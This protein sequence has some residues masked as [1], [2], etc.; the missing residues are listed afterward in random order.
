VIIIFGHVS[1][2]EVVKSINKSINKNDNES[3]MKPLFEKGIINRILVNKFVNKLKNMI[4]KGTIILNIGGYGTEIIGEDY[5]NSSLKA[6]MIVYDSKAIW[7]I[8]FKN[9]IG[10]SE[11]YILK[12]FDTDD[13]HNLLRIFILNRELGHSDLSSDKYSY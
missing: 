5:N 12:Y 1:A 9:D 2:L 13:M 7:K 6:N 10:F 8:L 11:A 4:K 3:I